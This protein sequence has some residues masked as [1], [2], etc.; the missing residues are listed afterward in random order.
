MNLIWNLNYVWYGNEYYCDT[1]FCIGG[2]VTVSWKVCSTGTVVV[3][4][5]GFSC[6][7]KETPIG[8]HDQ[9]VYLKF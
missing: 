3:L 5:V 9:V 6:G 2:V 7:C 8:I 1:R 4:C